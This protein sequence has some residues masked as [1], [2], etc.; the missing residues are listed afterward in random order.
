MSNLKIGDLVRSNVATMV[1]LFEERLD[2]VG[3]WLLTAIDAALIVGFVTVERD[4]CLV[5]EAIV[6]IK[7]KR[8]IGSTRHL[9]KIA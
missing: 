8:Y 9:E 5:E 3:P 2:E 4:D 7:N 1:M 6:I